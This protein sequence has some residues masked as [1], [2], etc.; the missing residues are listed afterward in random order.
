MGICTYCGAKAGWF[1]DAH[2]KCAEKAL[3]GQ[4]EIQQAVKLAV[5]NNQ[6]LRDLQAA[7]E[8]IRAQSNVP[9]TDLISAVMAGWS[10]GATIRAQAAPLSD[11]DDSAMEAIFKAYGLTPE[12][13]VKTE[14][15][16]Q[17]AASLI[18]WH[19]LHDSIIPYEG[20]VRFNLQRGEVAVFGIA[21]VVLSEER[22]ATSYVGGYSGASV[23]VGRGLYY[24]L[25]GVR[26]HREEHTAI[27]EVD[28]GLFLM[29]TQG[30]YFGGDHQNFRVPFNRIV[31]F[32]PYSDGVG[33]CKDGG[34]EQIF[35]P[36]RSANLGWFMYNTVQA[37]SQKT[38]DAA[39]GR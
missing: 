6:L 26:G 2:S 39:A 11:G 3:A 5:V 23:R 9:Q 35:A 34:K 10:E 1:S 33:I 38:N 22:T 36:V 18:L 27:Q 13:M 15:F 25:G 7:V 30:I 24:H 20:P 19:V 12:Q 21:N 29:T 8:T 28:Y 17:M 14:G 16:L 4:Q 32:Q 37:L 31:R